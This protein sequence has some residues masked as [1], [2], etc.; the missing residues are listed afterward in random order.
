MS[1]LT[2]PRLSF[3]G[4][5][6]AD[7]STVNNF[8]ANFERERYT[9]AD[10]DNWDIGYWNPYGTAVWR[11]VDCTVTGAVRA[12]G[13][14]VTDDPVLGMV[15]TDT[16]DQPPAKMVDLDSEQQMV[17][18]I[19]GLQVRLLGKDG[20]SKLRSNF[21]VASFTDLW[22]RSWAQDPSLEYP[23]HPPSLMAACWQSV[24]TDVGWDHVFDSPFLM[25]LRDAAQDGLLSIKF[26]V[27][28]YNAGYGV[29]GD[30][31]RHLPNPPGFTTG[32]ITGSIG[33]ASKAEPRHAPLARRLQPV[34][35]N[36]NA[37]TPF[38]YA[39]ALVDEP[40]KALVVDLGN[41]LPYATWR[42]RL[43]GTPF[44]I[45]YVDT[46][47]TF[48]ALGDIKPDDAWYESTAGILA[49]PLDDAQIAAVADKPLAV[50]D[51]AR[52]TLVAQESPDGRVVRADQFVFRLAP[53][54]ATP[55]TLWATRFG[56]PLANADI[57]LAFDPS[58]LQTGAGDTPPVG[59][60]TRALHFPDTVTTD[61]NGMATLAL[62]AT[63]PGEPRKADDI[64]GQVYGVRPAFAD[65]SWASYYNPWD[66][67]SVLV[68]SGYQIPEAPTWERDIK[69]ILTQ[70]ANLYPVMLPV[71]DMGEYDSVM[72]HLGVLY[73]TMSV[74]EEDPN[75]MP[76]VRDLSPNKR[77]AVLKWCQNP[78][79]GVPAP[80]TP[81][82]QPDA[83]ARPSAEGFPAAAGPV[84]RPHPSNHLKK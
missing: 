50:Y 65:A 22:A 26:N 55:V 52:Q 38:Y 13:T 82:A 60:P 15:V 58:G 47:E 67:I 68:W 72:K 41:S 42:G 30:G 17:S 76:V 7:V 46:P 48:R 27:Y 23:L 8:P 63:D 4:K 9:K 11:L 81:P 78:V 35:A 53:E 66:F 3:A 59:A 12:N 39:S 49:L 36:P 74:P 20:A 69:P 62:R 25:H 34:A 57:A 84:R 6:I 2:G 71:L 61:A 24:L 56:K 19:W 1:Y 32:L 40:N 16:D 5:F 77:A 51:P 45:G 29:F 79:R 31:V 80:A 44:Q 73:Y 83:A 28:G 64:D 14:T 37:P 75:Y 33:V 54:A 43:V 18:A 10:Y 21:A 70:Y